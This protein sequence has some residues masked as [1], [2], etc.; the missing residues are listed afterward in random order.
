MTGVS[1]EGQYT[2]KLSDN[3]AVSN[4]HTVNPQVC[5]VNLLAR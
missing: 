1:D 4:N 2:V 5:A 3:T